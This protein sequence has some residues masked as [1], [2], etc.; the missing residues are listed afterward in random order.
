SQRARRGRGAREAQRTVRR[1]GGADVSPRESGE[2]RDALRDR[3][4]HRS[5]RL[6]Q[7]DRRGSARDAAK[8]AAHRQEAAQRRYLVTGA[9]PH[10]GMMLA[11]SRSMLNHR[12]MRVTEA[13]SKTVAQRPAALR[14]RTTELARAGG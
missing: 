13:E 14:R 3:R 5:A 1:N 7:M 6:A 4:R 10:M 2:H 8:R 12:D 9:A 11:R